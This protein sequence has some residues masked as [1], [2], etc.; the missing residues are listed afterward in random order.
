[1][2]WLV[3]LRHFY[4]RKEDYMIFIKDLGVGDSFSDRFMK[5]GYE[6]GYIY[7]IWD[8]YTSK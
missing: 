7:L 5:W 8:Q 6:K 4:T 2:Q 3:K 1:M